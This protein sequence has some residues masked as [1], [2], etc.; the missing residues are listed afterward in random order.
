MIIPWKWRKIPTQSPQE[1]GL[2]GSLAASDRDQTGW[3]WMK[4]AETAVD[5]FEAPRKV[6]LVLMSVFMHPLPSMLTASFR[7]SLEEGI[8]RLA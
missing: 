6:V 7:K 4:L 2:S 5:H 3:K 1:A 8:P